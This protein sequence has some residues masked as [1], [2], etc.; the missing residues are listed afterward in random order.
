MSP[1]SEVRVGTLTAALTAASTF[2]DASEITL[3]VM[4]EVCASG[5]Q[6]WSEGAL[7]RGQV[8]LHGSGRAALAVLDLAD[9][10][11]CWPE[12]DYGPQHG[13]TAWHWI[14]RR[15]GPVALDVA[16]KAVRSL[17]GDDEAPAQEPA[18][19]SRRAFASQELYLRRQTTHLLA[20]PLY[21]AGGSLLGLATLE[22]ASPLT[23]DLVA[24]RWRVV[25]PELEDLARVVG[26]TLAR[27]PVRGGALGTVDL[28]VVGQAM[29]G[30]LSTLQAFAR[31]DQLIM[32]R[33]ATGVGKTHLARWIH[34][35]SARS[36]GPFVVADLVSTPTAG[37]EVA[38][39]GVVDRFFSGVRAHRG[40]VAE[41]L[42]GTLFIDEIDKL[43]LE[44]QARLLRLLDLR[45]YTVVGDSR[46]RR[47]DLRLIVATNVDLHEAVRQGRFR[48][49]L[50]YRVDVLA[51]EVPP[52]SERTDEI[53]GWAQHMLE[54]LEKEEAS[55]QKRSPQVLRLDD[56]VI[57][58][59]V[60]REWPGNLRELAT[61]VRRT[62]AVRGDG[63]VLGLE[64]L[65]AGEAIS[66]RVARPVGASSAEASPPDAGEALQARLERIVGELLTV[67]EQRRA[68]GLAPLCEQRGDLALLDWVEARILEGAIKRKG[69]L[70]EGLE[71]L[72]LGKKAE[73]GNGARIRKWME[74]VLRRVKVG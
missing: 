9:G 33:G 4:L 30:V 1:L 18:T 7:L 70:R 61:V 23:L 39:F 20:L 67:I 38:L 37:Q 25:L 53:A 11:V 71:L 73:A 26:P 57:A 14:Q 65:E 5:L 36:A 50:L 63:A 17:C 32:L 13:A 3:R 29:R 21:D 28:P 27:L 44:L 74:G 51:V 55:G 24:P 42:G 16:R 72:G 15:G 60:A 68:A 58:R 64:A 45:E 35:R 12:P 69:R 31:L 52:L 2:E 59:L 6:G 22:L 19:R 40:W 10:V 47:A 66:R 62:Y 46:T 54:H 8:Q 48:E 49:D 34:Q 41:A 43:S 56:A